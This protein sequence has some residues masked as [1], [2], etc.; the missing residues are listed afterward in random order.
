VTRHAARQAG[1]HNA[2]Y[3]SP[4][5]DRLVIELQRTFG[6]NERGEIYKQLA[7]LTRADMPLVPLY[8][9][10]DVFA[11][12]PDLRWQPRVDGQLRAAEMSFER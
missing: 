8:N 11:S 2:G 7:E 10:R 12:R 6:A 4:E 1:G 3:S 5:L 9:R